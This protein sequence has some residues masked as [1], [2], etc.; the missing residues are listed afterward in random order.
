MCQKQTFIEIVGEAGVVT[1]AAPDA[2]GA[3]VGL[4]FW[5][6]GSDSWKLLRLGQLLDQETFVTAILGDKMTHIV[7]LNFGNNSN[8]DQARE[9]YD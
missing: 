9:L 7:D 4:G 2:A 1:G 5:R 8:D 3:S 6:W